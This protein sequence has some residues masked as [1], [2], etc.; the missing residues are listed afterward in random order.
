[1]RSGIPGVSTI[2]VGVRYNLIMSRT[3]TI[4]GNQLTDALR[5]LGVNFILGGSHGIMRLHKQPARLIAALSESSE[6]RLPCR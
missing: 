5:S 2:P 3:T 1:M 4:T 6:A